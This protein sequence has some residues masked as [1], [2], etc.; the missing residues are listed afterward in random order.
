MSF[1]CLDTNHFFVIITQFL[2]ANL[3]FSNT[4]ETLAIVETVC[5]NISRPNG[6]TTT[7]EFSLLFLPEFQKTLVE[8]K[9]SGQLPTTASTATTPPTTSFTAAPST[10]SPASSKTAVDVTQSSTKQQSAD[11][12]ASDSPNNTFQN[13]NAHT[14]TTATATAPSTTT[15]D[16]QGET[17]ETRDENGRGP[18]PNPIRS[19]QI[20]F[21]DVLQLQKINENEWKN[22]ATIRAAWSTVDPSLFMLRGPNYLSDKKKIPSKFHIYTPVA[23]DIVHTKK[24]YFDISSKIFWNPTIPNQQLING[25]PTRLTI[26]MTFPS[27]D[28]ENAIWGKQVLDGKCQVWLVTFVLSPEAILQLTGA[29]PLSVG[30]AYCREFLSKN[31]PHHGCFK[32]IFQLANSEDATVSAALGFTGR[33][34]LR[35][36][37][38]KPYLSNNSHRMKRVGCGGG[39]CCCCCC[40][41]FVLVLV[42]AAVVVVIH[43]TKSMCLFLYPSSPPPQYTYRV[44][45]MYDC[46]KISIHLVI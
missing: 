36:Y 20:Q 6:L 37:N 26:E 45:V 27:F 7:S 33:T 2:E 40:C 23:I 44:L 18:N 42:V 11:A 30:V 35:N 12:T 43:L 1:R 4:P 24:R 29:Q 14:T 38:G 32:T 13:N 41:C 16:E 25:M 21:G 5:M 34:M 9:T 15:T 46:A 19:N 28:A 3:G 31:D 10:S 39:C 22:D 17:K 8:L